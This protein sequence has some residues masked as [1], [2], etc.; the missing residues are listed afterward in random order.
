MRRFSEVM[1]NRATLIFGGAVTTMLVL[2]VTAFAGGFAG[3]PHAGGGSGGS[4]TASAGLAVLS[5]LIAAAVLFVWVIGRRS[6]EREP[7]ATHMRVTNVQ[8]KAVSSASKRSAP[9][10]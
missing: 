10:A 8:P 3:S 9:V 7:A 1:R 5:V 2:P 6:V 4:S